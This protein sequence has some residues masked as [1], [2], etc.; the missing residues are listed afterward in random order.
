[1]QNNIIF[2]ILALISIASSLLMIYSRRPI[3]AALSFIITLISIA[4]LFALLGSTFLF[5]VE[6][7]IYAGAVLTLI[8]FIIMFLN[9]KD[10]NLP[11]EQFKNIW[12]VVSA[13]LIAPFSYMLI[14]I[15]VLSDLNLQAEK[16]EHFGEI[17]EIGML[18]YSKWVLPFELL[19]VLLLVA[20][21]GAIILAK[22]DKVHD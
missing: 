10:K 3:D 11:D 18:L 9:I 17:K 14:K 20:L 16:N 4:A 19:S 2:T 5:A 8:L 21:L 7:I 13:F 15:I 12:M 22:K 1:M 6:I